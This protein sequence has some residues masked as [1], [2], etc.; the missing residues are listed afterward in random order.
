ME[1][2]ENKPSA[3]NPYQLLNLKLSPVAQSAAGMHAVM[4]AMGNLVEEKTFFRGNLALLSMN[5]F[6][7]FDCPS[8]AWPDPDDE[9]SPVGEYCE[10]GA[11]ALAEEATT[12]K[13][14]ADFFKQHS[15]YE[16]AKLD[17][18]QIGKFGRLTEPMYMPKGGTHYEPI[19]W[20]H[21]FNKIAGHLN[22][23][24]SPHQAAFYTSGRTSNEASFVYQLF[25]KEF[26]TNNMPDCSNMCH[27][28][29][30]SALR[31]TIGIGK[32]T[33]T[34]EDFYETDL[35]IEIGHNPGTNAP[36]MMSA[37]A[38]AKKKRCKNY[39]H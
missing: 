11:K 5:Q 6:K 31:P 26:G 27:E 22:A 34:L 35:I 20:D 19:S 10:N 24:Q 1:N 32:G 21:A 3:E 17:D 39:C 15:V 33:V 28:T 36:R 25:A 30:G 18:Y 29:S 4:A 38:K 2:N 7:G 16:L 37:L 8:C 13:V 14:T 23:L 12:K 9:R